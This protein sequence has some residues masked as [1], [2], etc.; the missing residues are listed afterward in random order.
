MR[1]DAVIQTFVNIGFTTPAATLG[2]AH[3]WRDHSTAGDA[4]NIIPAYAAC[5]FFRP[6]IRCEVYGQELKRRVVACAEGAATATGAKL[7]WRRI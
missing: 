7:E 6:I 4:P 5:R 2:G 3:S 1:S